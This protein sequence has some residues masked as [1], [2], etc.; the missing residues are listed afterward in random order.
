MNATKEVKAVSFEGQVFSV[1][2]DVHKKSWNVT[3]VKNSIFLK[4]FSIQPDTSLLISI[5]G[6]KYPDGKFEFCYEAGFCGFWIQRDLNK[7]GYKC[8]VVNPADVPTTQ[9]DKV[10]KSDS[11]DSRKLAHE[12]SNNSLQ[13]I[14]IPIVEEEAY[15]DV[16]RYRSSLIKKQTSI[17]NQIKSLLDKYGI[18]GL[19]SKWSNKYIAWLDEIVFPHK[20]SK[21]VL[22]SYVTD[23]AYISNKIKDVTKK[24]KELLSS[25]PKQEEAFNILKSIPGVG[26][27]CA[28]TLIAEIGN[29]D[30]FENDDQFCSY[31]GLIPMTKDSGEKNSSRGITFRHKQKLRDMLIESSW[32]AARE[33]PTM[34]IRFEELSK[35]FKKV[36]ASYVR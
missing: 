21:L 1:G 16:Y 9:K 10:T 24:L 12:L 34:I 2:M 19:T 22:D 27:I 30:R 26:D 5:L 32:I 23:L 7:L 20:Y 14:Y 29:V 25:D 8:I 3:V 18:E 31:I 15:R 33:D 17:K 4:R 6:K 11:V 28:L 13:P 36:M 35:R